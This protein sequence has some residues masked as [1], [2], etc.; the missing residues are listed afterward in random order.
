M[1]KVATRS[2]SGGSA[3]HARALADALDA[4]RLGVVGLSGGGA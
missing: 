2:T 3:P 4:E 1:A